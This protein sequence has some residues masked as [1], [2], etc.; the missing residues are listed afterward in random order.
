MEDH[1][2]VLYFKTGLDRG[3]SPKDA[4]AFAVEC[5]A[6]EAKRYGKNRP[7][8]Q[9]ADVRTVADLIEIVVSRNEPIRI[10]VLREAA[11]NLVDTKW[12]EA[13]EM[14]DVEHT[15]AGFRAKM[16]F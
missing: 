2:W 16:P 3:M 7:D 11:S 15:V 9:P 14:A 1:G 12:L 10:A 13:L 8:G 6:L 5:E 4:A